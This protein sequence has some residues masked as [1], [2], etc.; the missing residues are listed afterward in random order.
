MQEV[1]SDLREDLSRTKNDCMQL[2]GTKSGLQQRMADQEEKLSQ[3]KAEFLRSDFE[4][5]SL[6]SEKVRYQ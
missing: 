1:A 4:K 3:L 5:Q 2:Q 6:E